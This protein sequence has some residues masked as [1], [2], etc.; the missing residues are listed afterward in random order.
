MNSETLHYLRK[1]SATKNKVREKQDHWRECKL[2]LAT[3]DLVNSGWL[4][5]R[6]F[7]DDLLSHFFHKQHE[8]VEWFLDVDL[9]LSGSTCCSSCRWWWWWSGAG[10]TVESD[11]AVRSVA[12]PPKNHFAPLSR[13]NWARTLQRYSH[14]RVALLWDTDW[15][16]IV[17]IF[18]FIIFNEDINENLMEIVSKMIDRTIFV[19]TLCRVSLISDAWEGTIQLFDAVK[20]PKM[21]FCC[22][23]QP[24][25]TF[26]H[27][28]SLSKL[29]RPW[30]VGK[31][32]NQ[33]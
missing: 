3:E 28:A 7:V 10:D 31:D 16:K 25:R 20:C 6:T 18:S 8:S 19:K 2:Y 1:A 5:K 27:H 12:K 30:G 15:K 17:C 32:Q 11:G 24:N 9:S 33:D 21:T 13:I 22:S 23:K 29:T 4:F 26:L 14:G